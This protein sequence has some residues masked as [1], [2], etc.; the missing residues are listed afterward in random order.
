M[1][2]GVGAVARRLGVAPSTLR[3]WER[4]Y[5]IAPSRHTA[6]GHRRYDETDVARLELMQRLI[7]GGVP[8]EEAARAARAAGPGELAAPPAP[9]AAAVPAG[10]APAV[11]ALVRAAAAMDAAAMRRLVR[12][13]LDRD[14]VA[15]AWPGLLA[16]A[17][18]EI[19]ARQAAGGVPVEVEHLLSDCVLGALAAVAAAAGPPVTTRPVLL[20]CAPEEQ[21]SLPVQA[22][23]AGLAQEGL[24]VR[25]LGARVPYPALAG[26][27]RR[28]GPA[29][30]FVWSSTAETGDPRPLADLPGT[31]PALR[32]IVGGPGWAD[33]ALPAGTRRVRT[34]AGAVA[35]AR[36]A[37]GLD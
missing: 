32:L 8:P 4:R 36:A 12:D 26:A 13:A 1:G 37:L 3:T 14:G 35:A 17:L 15:G 11:R 34:Y 6:G 10:E 31:R 7:L 9:P 27:I 30:V 18:I 5:R 23:G 16:P 22:L 21:H 25:V 29:A 28:T 2:L 19:G 33:G 20:A 24:E